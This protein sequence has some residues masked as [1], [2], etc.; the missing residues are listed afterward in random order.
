MAHLTLIS[1]ALAGCGDGGGV[2]ST[3][4][5]PTYQT[6]QQIASQGGNS[7]FSTSGVQ[8]NATPSTSSASSNPYGSGV[9]VAYNASSQTYTLTAPDGTTASFSPNNLY[10]AATTANSVQ[11]I[12]STGSGSSEVEDN[13]TLGTASVNGV[14][15]SYTM[16]GEWIHINASGLSVWLATG[17]VPTLASD[18]PKT[19]TATYSVAV[20]G[21]AQLG[22]QDYSVQPTNS[23]GTFSANFG[24][25]TVATSLTLGGTPTVAGV[26]T[27]T[28]F[29]TFNGT[30][31]IT[32]GGPGFTG[33][34]SVGSN[35][36]VFTGNFNGPQAAEVGYSW[37][38]NTGN[39]SASGITV[40]KK[41]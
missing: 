41:N 35:P 38:I 39:F 10:S 18:M 9:M 13:L 1:L 15:L 40:G 5:P 33:T 7:N 23:S 19:G 22:G 16:F 3:P 11:Y 36:S 17:G 37:A 30:G 2:A 12:K 27:A 29:G 28:T 21:G 32:T 26:G 8:I 4:P 20:N 31:T 6:L 34:F 14:A 25:G 24:A